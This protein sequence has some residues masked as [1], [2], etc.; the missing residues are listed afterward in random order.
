M[1]FMVAFMATLVTLLLYTQVGREETLIISAI[2]GFNAALV[3]MISHSG[4]DNLLIPLTTFAFISIHIGHD[5]QMLRMHLMIFG[6]IFILVTIANRV[7][8]LSKIAIV[9][10][11][12]VGYLTAI[13]YGGY[14]LI[15]PLFTIMTVMRFPKRRKNEKSN[16]YDARIIET[17]V[18]I[19][20]AICGIAAITGWR[21]E[22]FMIYA[23]SYAMHLIINTF[24]RFKYYL[25][26]SEIDSILFAIC[27]G[28]GFVFIPSLIVYNIT[29][30]EMINIYMLMTMIIAMILSSIM[31]YTKKKNVI[32]E[33]ILMSNAYM[34]M[35]IVLILT[36]L[37]GGV[38][39]LQ[40]I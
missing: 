25:N 20:I 40:I 28:I 1:F 32:K 16:L 33:E 38:Q 30:G 31:I 6:V 3:E 39:I 14:A 12:V 17:N 19:P 23:S 27:K 22:L 36:I 8:I 7:K 10:A 21:K 34:H 37:I 9:E 13:L 11:I 24:V 15:P 35:K 5:L 18:I 26:F 29:F 4:N 2:V